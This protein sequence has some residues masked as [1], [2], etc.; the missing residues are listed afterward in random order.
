MLHVV[1]AGRRFPSVG[2]FPQVPSGEALAETPSEEGKQGGRSM[3]SRPMDGGN[4]HVSIASP[5]VG[6][7]ELLHVGLLP[8]AIAMVIAESVI[9]VVV[10]VP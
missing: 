1:L 5:A 10:R 7:H 9:V 8:T 2:R 3:K 4:I 6:S